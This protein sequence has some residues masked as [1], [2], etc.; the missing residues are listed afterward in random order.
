MK[1]L[2]SDRT[3]LR[4]VWEK[5]ENSVREKNIKETFLQKQR[6]GNIDNVWFCDF[7]N[8]SISKANTTRDNTQNHKIE[9]LEKMKEII[10]FYHPQKNSKQ[11]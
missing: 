2:L 10:L 9:V 6:V 1:C 8:I 3:I 11:N 4:K 7:F 5:L